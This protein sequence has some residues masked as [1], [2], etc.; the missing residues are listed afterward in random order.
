MASTPV[1]SLDW[2]EKR[3]CCLCNGNIKDSEPVSK[4][5]DEGLHSIQQLAERWVK[6]NQSLC[7]QAQY[8]EFQSAA[9]RLSRSYHDIHILFMRTVELHFGPDLPER[10]PSQASF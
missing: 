7:T 4:L 5:T 3:K 6:I 9:L 8:V 2:D 10:K 1:L